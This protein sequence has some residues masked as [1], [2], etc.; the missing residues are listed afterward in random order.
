MGTQ[1]CEV[2][3]TP[4]P[5]SESNRKDTVILCRSFFLSQGLKHDNE[6]EEDPSDIPIFGTFP[7]L[8]FRFAGWFRF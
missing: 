1:G 3:T 2:I 8:T 5:L 7:F 6:K 4:P